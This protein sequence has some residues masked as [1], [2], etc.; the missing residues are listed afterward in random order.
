MYYQSLE[1]LLADFDVQLVFF[2]EDVLHLHVGYGHGVNA[3]NGGYDVTFAKAS[4]FGLTSGIDLKT[5]IVYLTICS[6]EI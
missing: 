1:L 5:N 4:L 3:V 2:L 6:R